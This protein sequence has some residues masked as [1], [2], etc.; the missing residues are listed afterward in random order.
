MTE[1]TIAGM[2]EAIS[3]AQLCHMGHHAWVPWLRL[4][5]GSWVTWCAREYCDHKEQWDE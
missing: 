5:N 2:L 4:D 1:P 3:N